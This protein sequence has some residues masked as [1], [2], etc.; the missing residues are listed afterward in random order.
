MATAFEREQLFRA[1]VE[2]DRKLAQVSTLYR[3]QFPQ[4]SAQEAP[5]RPDPPGLTKPKPRPRQDF[6]PDRLSSVP[7]WQLAV[8][9]VARD[10]AGELARRDHEQALAAHKKALGERDGTLARLKAERD[11]EG[12]LLI[13]AHQRLLDGN[14]TVMRRTLATR[15]RDAP[16]PSSLVHL[17]DGHAHLA[18]RA[19]SLSSLVPDRAPTTT[20][21]GTST[22]RK[23][24]QTETN[25]L[26]A[27][28]VCG[29]ALTAAA[30]ALTAAPTLERVSVLVTEGT[31]RNAP[32]I[33]FCS[34][35]REDLPKTR[36]ISDPIAAFYDNAGILEQAGRTH[37]LKPLYLAGDPRLRWIIGLLATSP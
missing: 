19:L 30:I 11:A 7:R 16:V 14:E 24:G 2:D 9:R 3:R 10:Q 32:V 34:V 15:L 23:R 25:N 29:L 1:A 4:P 17:L 35:A 31:G 8:R 27:E 26:Y 18:L 28:V 6:E 37:E 20:A 36:E 12:R 5:A 22:T 33:A 21:K 13:A